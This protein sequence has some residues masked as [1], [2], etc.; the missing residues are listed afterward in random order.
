MSS[1]L[2]IGDRQFHSDQLISALVQYKLLEPLI[3]QVLLDD[4]LKEVPVSRQELY[5][6]LSGTQDT[7][8]PEDFEGFLQ[9]WCQHQGVTADY[10][11]QVI[12]RQF[13]LQKFQQLQFAHQIES[14]FLRLKADLDQVEYSLIQVLDLALAQELY[15]QLRDDGA[16]FARLA[17]RYSLSHERETGGWIGPV[18]LSSLPVEVAM[19]FRGQQ[20]GVLYG[21]LPVAD[22]FWVVRLEHY[23]SARLTEANR[24]YLANRLY[25]EW[26][27]QQTRQLIDTPGAIVVQPTT[28]SLP[29][30]AAA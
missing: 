10:F 17:N 20:P 2:K 7:P 3:G 1:Y 28:P 16:S 21:P 15:F 18:P 14:E 12:L 26:L 30:N 9:Q 5:Q 13:R 27:S 4:V 8:P 25:S 22:G 23:I 6:R 29:A 19:L 24:L 11:N